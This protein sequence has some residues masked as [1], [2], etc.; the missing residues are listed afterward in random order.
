MFYKKIFSYIKLRKTPV[1]KYWICCD[2]AYIKNL[3]Y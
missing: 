2:Y 3:Y 1:K